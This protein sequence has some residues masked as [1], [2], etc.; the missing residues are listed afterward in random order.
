MTG[1][2]ISFNGKMIS[3]GPLIKS[4]F[5]IRPEEPNPLVLDE[6]R[7][8]RNDESLCSDRTPTQNRLDEAPQSH[9]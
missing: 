5:S 1:Q 9:R 2:N 7:L 3:M 8:P 4:G 6:D